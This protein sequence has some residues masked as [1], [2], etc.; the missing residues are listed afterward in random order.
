MKPSIGA[1]SR[2]LRGTAWRLWATGRECGRTQL[3]G[4][5]VDAPGRRARSTWA[6]FEAV[7]LTPLLFAG[8]IHYPSQLGV[9]DAAVTRSLPPTPRK[10]RADLRRT[11]T[12][13]EPSIDEESTRPGA[14]LRSFSSNDS[15]APTTAEVTAEGPA[16]P[17][18]ILSLDLKLGHPA[19]P[20][21]ALPALIDSLSVEVVAGL[22]SRCFTESLVSLSALR[23]RVVDTS[24]R[25]LVTGDLNAGKSTFINAL[26]RRDVMPSDQQPCTSVF[27]EVLDAAS[28]ND[29]REEIHAI[30]D[31]GKYDPKDDA[32]FDR[33]PLAQVQ[34]VQDSPADT[35]QI[36]KAYVTDARAPASSE[37]SNPSFIK[38]GLVSISLIDAPGLNRDT[39]STTALFAR[40]SEIDVI[41]FVVSAENH[42]TLSANEFLTTA[43]REKAYVFI[44]VNKWGAIKDKARCMRVV[45]DQIKKLS[46][47]TWESR[48]ELVHFVDAAEALEDDSPSPSSDDP[49]NEAPSS[50]DH[51]E[52]S[53][54]SFV[55]L[56]RS[57]SKLAP[58]KHYLTN[59]LADLATLT[60]ANIIAA[61]VELKEALKALAIIKPVHERLAAQR[62][63]VEDGVD[64]VEEAVVQDVKHS[65]WARLERAM[66]F[67]VEGEVVPPTEA[68]AIRPKFKGID[69]ISAP[70]ALP[71]YPGV[72]SL[73]TWA[74]DVKRT[75][76]R[77][78]EAEV[79]A[80]EDDARVSTV[81]GV[82]KVMSDLATRYLP[83]DEAKDGANGRIFR[84][85]VMFAK[86][87][88]GV[89]KLAARGVASGLGLGA[90][91][92]S[93]GWSAAEFDVSFLDFFDLE[94]VYSSAGGKGKALEDDS[95][96][97]G[98]IVSLGLGGMGMIGS[99]LIGVKG[100]LDTVS[101]VV[102][103]LGSKQA[104][105][106]AAPVIGVLSSF[107]PSSPL[108]SLLTLAPTAV[109]LAAY[110]VYDIPRALPRNIGRKLQS[111]LSSPTPSSSSSSSTT[112]AP[113]TTFASAHSERISRETRKVLRLAGWDLRERF[114]AALE[115][116]AAEREEVEGKLKRA[117]GAVE[118]LG[119]FEGRVEGVE[120]G[121]GG[122]EV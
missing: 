4:T 110:L 112:E 117:E 39:L 113:P 6:H 111:S 119:E 7:S 15:T 1:A 53:L 86:R 20:T 71:P 2:N 68:D 115:K 32:T 18:S 65:A 46:P 43:S 83:G 42:F 120:K 61:S 99:R 57:K 85:E 81:D 55:L 24:S 59:L 3:A 36:L 97:T 96:E 64:K 77:S 14:P 100:T 105:E 106:W 108:S 88:R 66:G 28:Y 16:H 63:E 91:G 90:A 33:F 76:V 95:L 51:L 84:P 94:R 22:M 73:W 27:C 58:A 13:H 78:L 19:A 54:R 114:R 72:F 118:W 109:G 29:N 116:S 70:T 60:D 9:A 34:D 38:N 26:L 12:S 104:R 92:L 49:V 40:Q 11:Q 56:K 48:G 31:M 87:R 50:F 93:T 82:H 80:S 67:V 30:R 121:V 35:Y 122:V 10:P 52:Q 101:R 17:L 89:G 74:S 79:R 41:V 23:T 25:I 37:D 107:F 102:E 69:S 62:D 21:A 44:V 5:A 98:A 8:T 45:G 47:A 103:I 75:L